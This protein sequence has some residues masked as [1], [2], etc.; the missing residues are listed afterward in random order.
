MVEEVSTQL[1]KE[2]SNPEA[3]PFKDDLVPNPYPLSNEIVKNNKN[4]CIKITE[5]KKTYP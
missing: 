3:K 2:I 5:I 4:K 1:L